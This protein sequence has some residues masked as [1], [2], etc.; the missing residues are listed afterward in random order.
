MGEDLL[1][2]RRKKFEMFVHTHLHFTQSFRFPY[3]INAYIIDV[4]AKKPAVKH[5]WHWYCIALHKFQKAESRSAWVT[6]Y[7]LL[8]S[9]CSGSPE[10]FIGKEKKGKF[11]VLFPCLNETENVILTSF[12]NLEIYGCQ[13]NFEK[14]HIRNP[15]INSIQPC[16]C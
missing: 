9:H 6:Y 8:L 14:F 16:I 5:N 11:T 10:L 7:S 1:F 13:L 12:G 15:C 3:I 4:Y 2:S